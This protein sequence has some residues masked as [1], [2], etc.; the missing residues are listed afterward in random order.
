MLKVLIVDD[1]TFSRTD[2]KT[3]IDWEGQGFLIIGEAANGINAIQLI[4]N[5][6][7][8]IV[9]TDMNMPS[10]NG[11]ELIDYIYGNHPNIRVIALSAYED[12]DYVRQSM[13]KGAMD[14]VLKHHLNTEALLDILEAARSS[15]SKYENERN[16]QNI[17]TEQLSSGRTILIQEFIHK[18]VAGD[19][20]DLDEIKSQLSFLDI[21]I[22]IENVVVS[23]A[24]ID[25]FSF[26]REKFSGKEMEILVKTFLDVSREILSDW[27]QSIIAHMEKGKFVLIFSLGKTYSMLYVYNRLF[28]ILDRIKGGIKKYLNITACFSVSK[29]YRDVTEI[30]KAYAE[31]DVILQD[32][33]YKGKNCIFMDNTGSKREEGFFCLDIKDEKA[34]ITAL[35][36]MD[37]TGI[38]ELID[39][40]FD[41]IS[42]LRLNIKATQMICAELI[43]IAN[44]ISKEMGFEVSQLYTNEDIPYNMMQKYETIMDMKDWILSLYS[45]LISMLGRVKV[46]GQCSE[47]TKK[48]IEFINRNYKKDVSLADVAEFTG[49]SSSYISRIFKED[50]KVGFVEY[51]NH[52]RVEN[53]KQFIENGE[54][55]LKEIVNKVGFNN[56]NYFF[57]VFK[58]IVGMTPIEY[59]QVCRR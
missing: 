14:Y 31:A 48:A 53:A 59:E 34:I 29:V 12:F 51:L 57:K 46:E 6:E 24:E 55:K 32:K 42:D 36:A 30:S 35:R 4:E 56:Y 54:H 1:D 25:D 26:I 28:T 17:I 41:K 49:V 19:I 39:N 11:V 23:I 27:E 43:S 3:M 5:E 40:I 52:V 21:K 33:F 47:I 15:I 2:M 44:K 58:E 37:A 20:S 50:C 7:P 38:K 16:K 22:D 9:I 18:L 8:D 13:K 10:M 45:K